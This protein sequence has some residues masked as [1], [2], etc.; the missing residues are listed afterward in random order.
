[1]SDLRR[2]LPSPHSIFV[3]EAA[4]RHLNFRNAAAE[5]NV[6][7]PSISHA[8][9]AFEDHTGVQ[10]FIRENRGVRLTDAG[11]QLYEAVRAGFNRIE[12]SLREIAADTGRYLTFAASTTVAAHWLMPQLYQLQEDHPDLKIKVLTTDRDAEPDAEVDMTIWIR[13]RDFQRPGSWWLCDEVVF[14]VCAPGYAASH[15]ALTGPDDLRHHRLLH[16]FDRH[17][18]RIS[19]NEWM[20]KAGSEPLATEP[21][22]IFNDFLLAIQAALAGEG[23]ALGWNMSFEL[24]LRNRLL[25]RPLSTEV[26]TGNA[27]FLIGPPEPSD[28]ASKLI[29][30][31]LERTEVLRAD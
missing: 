8:I 10:L 23:I 30:W 18:R 29:Q 22:M 19:W 21:A 6:T 4:A 31:L 3:F 11:R 20:V 15:P 26:R 5:L 1:M 25:V 7:Q 28:D 16:A 17:R 12:G 9:K 27:F 24:L 2:L 14:P 13:P